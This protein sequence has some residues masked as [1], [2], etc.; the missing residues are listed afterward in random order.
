MERAIAHTILA[1]VENGAIIEGVLKQ[2]G[3]QKCSICAGVGHTSIRCTTKRML[4]RKFAELGLRSSWGTIKNAI[5]RDNVDVALDLRDQIKRVKKEAKDD[6]ILWTQREVDVQ[7]GRRQRMENQV[8]NEPP[9]DQDLPLGAFED[10]RFRVRE[11][12]LPY[13]EDEMSVETPREGEE[14]VI[15]YQLET[16]FSSQKKGLRRDLTYTDSKKG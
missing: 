4:D 7:L 12:T 1:K 5:I 15:R 16:G 3:H 2:Y 9:A 14:R 8:A 11:D 13:E 6:R 10:L